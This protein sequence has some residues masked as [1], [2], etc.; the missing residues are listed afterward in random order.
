MA[1][2]AQCTLVNSGS[3]GKALRPGCPFI[4][5]NWPSSVLPGERNQQNAQI[6][7]PKLSLE[8]KDT[9]T[10]E[11]IEVVPNDRER[12][13][14]KA[15]QLTRRGTLKGVEEAYVSTPLFD[16]PKIE[17]EDFDACPPSV[18]RMSAIATGKSLLARRTNN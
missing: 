17:I 13:P 2:M 7:K 10:P 9:L 15:G 18:N 8:R 12:P 6:P 3:L 16:L 11:D 1:T 14:I 4:F 5:L